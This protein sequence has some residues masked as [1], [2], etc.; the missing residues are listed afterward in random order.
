MFKLEKVLQNL[1]AI[2]AE[3]YIL[4][5]AMTNYNTMEMEIS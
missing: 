1:M 5:L 3:K 4:H 2:E